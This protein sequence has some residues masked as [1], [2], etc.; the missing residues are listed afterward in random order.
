MAHLHGTADV[1]WMLHLKCLDARE[2]RFKLGRQSAMPN[3]SR[4][5]KL[6]ALGCA[7]SE[8]PYDMLGNVTCLDLSKVS[9]MLTVV[10]YN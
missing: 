7:H 4:S 8:G 9:E 3:M 5:R 2:G 10:V 6:S 1:A